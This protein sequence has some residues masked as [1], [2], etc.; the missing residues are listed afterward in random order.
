MIDDPHTLRCRAAELRRLAASIER[1][2][3]GTVL[4][5]AGTDT[6]LGPSAEACRHDLAASAE[7]LHRAVGTLRR[8]ASW[9]DERAAAGALAAAP[10]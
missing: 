4:P 2:H 8:D 6:W 1:V 10:S 5:L 7:A 3:F 9:L